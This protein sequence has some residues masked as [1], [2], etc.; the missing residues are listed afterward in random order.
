[1]EDRLESKGRDWTRDSHPLSLP[2]PVIVFEKHEKPRVAGGACVIP[3]ET[4]QRVRTLSGGK[5]FTLGIPGQRHLVLAAAM[6]ELC[7][8]SNTEW[9]PEVPFGLL[10]KNIAS[11]L[12]VVTID[13][14]TLEVVVEEKKASPFFIRT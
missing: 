1:M 12:R 14:L 8:M 5:P 13:F 7:A 9:K 11:N 3:A 10:L 6:R 2:I 4:D